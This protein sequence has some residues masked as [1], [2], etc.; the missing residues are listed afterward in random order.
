MQYVIMSDGKGS[1]WNHYL[2]ITKQEILIGNE[3]LIDRTVRLIRERV[4]APIFIL[5]SN[6][7]HESRGAT[8]ITSSYS[9]SLHKMYGY[10]YLNTGT[11]FLYGDTFYTISAMETILYN[12]EKD[13]VFYGNE[14]AIIGLKANNYMLLKNV[15]DQIDPSSSLYHAFDSMEEQRQFI[16][17]GDAY[18]NI[19]SPYDYEQFLQKQ[20]RLLWK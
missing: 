4:T 19:N 12:G 1:R 13:V 8:R 3:R 15:L 9:S 6:S 20:K 2:G 7:N 18:F 14:H 11:T 17:V 5:S 10:E 16:S